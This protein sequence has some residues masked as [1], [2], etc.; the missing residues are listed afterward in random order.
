MRGFCIIV[1]VLVSFFSSKNLLAQYQ[2]Q[3]VDAQN[4][5]YI[6]NAHLINQYGKVLATS[7][8]K[9]MIT[10][11]SYVEKRSMCISHV[12]YDTIWLNNNQV[13]LNKL[14]LQP[15][16][17]SLP[18]F[19]F[20]EKGPETVFHSLYHY[21]HDYAFY[22]D[23]IVLITFNKSVKDAELTVCNQNQEVLFEQPISGIPTGFIED[24]KGNIFLETERKTYQLNVLERSVILVEIDKKDYSFHLNNCV[25]SIENH[26]VFND[27]IEYLPRMNYYAFD[28]RD[29]NYFLLA[30]LTNEIV[31]KMYRWE[32]YEMSL[33]QKREAREIAEQI[34]TMDKKDVAAIMTGFHK[35]LY[36]EPVYAPLF[37]V[38]DTL[39]IFD[40]SA[41]FLY[42]IKD[43]KKVDSVSIDYHFSERRFLWKNRLVHDEV[44]Q[45][46]YG[47]FKKKGYFILK[48][49]DVETGTAIQ[50]FTVE[51][52]F[53]ENLEVYNGYVYYLYKKP[54]SPE[55]PFLYRERLF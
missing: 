6:S 27:F 48:E 45:K 1:M 50:S 18:E 20:E 2:V 4:Q 33:E 21:V 37:N 55:K 11:P 53:A 47:V 14:L 13:W 32:Y 5:S 43:F 35:S 39:L 51:K 16:T 12:S 8:K 23:K 7:N 15:K 40:H 49:V 41:N 34:P 10:L 26:I 30:S 17:Y 28:A 3:L 22:N 9:G 54:S 46:F 38:N 25:D 24:Y 42:R 52:Q 44:N 29:S 19:S 36:Y 31:N